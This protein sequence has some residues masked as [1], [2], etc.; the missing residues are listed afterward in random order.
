ML[1]VKAKSVVKYR[2]TAR[3]KVV[4]ESSWIPFLVFLALLWLSG[5]VIGMT[6]THVG[7][8]NFTKIK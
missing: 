3:D 2:Y 4:D 7:T 1:A 8:T 5:V 6:K